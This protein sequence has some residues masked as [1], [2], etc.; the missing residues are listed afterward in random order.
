MILI[1]I[2]L[3]CLIGFIFGLFPNIHINT[4]AYIFLLFGILNLFPN[5]FYLFLS[6]AIAS[7]VTNYIPTT[8]FGVP[9]PENI[10][11]MFPAQKLFL[12]GEGKKAI[13]LGLVGSF[14]GMFFS[15]IFFPLLFL[16]F[17]S[18][19]NF[20]IFI[21]LGIILVLFLFIYDNSNTKQR[22][23]SFCI[24]FI[25]GLLGIFTL[26]YNYF[27]FDTLFVCVFGLFALPMLIYSVYQKPVYIIQKNNLCKISFKKSVFFGFLGSLVSLFIILIPSFSSSQASTLVSKFKKLSSNE[28]LLIFSSIS[29]SALLFSFF[30]AINFFKPRL[31]YIAI[32]LNNSILP[33]NFDYFLFSL[34]SL[35]SC[36]FII[37]I[38][39]FFLDKI[40]YFINSFNI[41][42]LNFIIL[43]FSI[44]IVFLISGFKSLPLLILSTAIGFLPLIFNKSRIILMSYIMIPT[45]LFYI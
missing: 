12:K 10:M 32:L 42:K 37:L 26:K 27:S 29:I 6:I 43:I 28:Y 13:F 7:L 5:K 38:I 36:V 15:I 18:L 17:S 1:D 35:L 31:G 44:I 23:I 19:F 22:I 16:L 24:I 34:S 45:L 30:L 2:I 4:L 14:F 9:N 25:S 39:L 3:G 8:F 21:A 40:I 33:I 41:Y 11:F 20:H